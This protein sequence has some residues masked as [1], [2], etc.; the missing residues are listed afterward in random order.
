MVQA[1]A[2]PSV[3]ENEPLMVALDAIPLAVLLIDSTLLI[4]WVNRGAETL[5]G[6][7]GELLVGQSIAS[8]QNTRWIWTNGNNFHERIRNTFCGGDSI[9]GEERS[10]TLLVDGERVEKRVRVNTSPLGFAPDQMVL[11][12]LEDMRLQ[13][14]LEEKNRETETLN[15]TIQMV[16]AAAHELNQPLSVLVGN[17]DLLEHHPKVKGSFGKRMDRI[18]ESADRVAEAVRRL[19][20]IIQ[21]SKKHQI[22]K[23]GTADSV[24]TTAVV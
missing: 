24:K 9:C 12:V 10:L 15:M 3:Q 22:L 8:D 19:Q 13:K 5:F 17:L 6:C 23:T 21:S 20:M 4:R 1:K 2:T 14:E 7:G 16:R 11:M 18:S